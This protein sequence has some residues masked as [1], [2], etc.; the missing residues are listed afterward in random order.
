MLGVALA[1]GSVTVVALGV[2]APVAAGVVEGD[3]PGA[4]QAVGAAAG[5]AGVVPA[6]REP[7]PEWRSACSSRGS[8]WASA[9]PR[10]SE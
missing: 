6:A 7:D 10:P 5:I 4:I 2:P 1:L 3:R 8:C 9:W